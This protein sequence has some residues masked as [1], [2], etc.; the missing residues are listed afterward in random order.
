MK[1]LI[2]KIKKFRDERDWKQFHDIKDLL[3]GLN[4]EVAELQELFLWKDE[5]KDKD[6]LEDVKG[7]VSDIF[8]FLIFICEKL[9]INLEKAVKEKLEIHKKHYPKNLPKGKTTKYTDL[10]K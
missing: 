3:L 1:D 5:N 6:N 8:I 2:E 7:E 4:I 10:N 9:E